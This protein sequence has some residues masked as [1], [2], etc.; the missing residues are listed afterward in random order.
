ME[1]EQ[2]STTRKFNNQY[3]TPLNVINPE[4]EKGFFV[5]A[6]SDSSSS[7]FAPYTLDSMRRE[8]RLN[9]VGTS[10]SSTDS[11]SQEQAPLMNEQQTSDSMPLPRVSERVTPCPQKPTIAEMIEGFEK[12]DYCIIFLI[13]FMVLLGCAIVIFLL[14][15]CK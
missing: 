13:I 2:L 12:F 9:E 11:S 15:F 6:T 7:S 14:Y 4:I 3:S 8:A 5:S 10:D 1:L